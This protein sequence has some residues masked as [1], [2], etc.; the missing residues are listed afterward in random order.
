MF[1]VNPLLEYGVIGRVG[2]IS[3]ELNALSDAQ[4]RD[5]GIERPMIHE[6]AEALARRAKV[7]VKRGLIA[8]GL[9]LA[10]LF[11]AYRSA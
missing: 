7:A 6:I 8:R 3:R 5:I 4:L 1:H 2:G 10:P 9:S 11:Q